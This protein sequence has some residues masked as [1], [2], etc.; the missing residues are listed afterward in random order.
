MR[1]ATE[2][3]QGLLNNRFNDRRMEFRFEESEMANAA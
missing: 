1:L 3:D 2:V